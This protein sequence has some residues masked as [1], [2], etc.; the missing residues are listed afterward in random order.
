MAARGKT[1]PKP[2]PTDPTVGFQFQRE[3]EKGNRGFRVH[4]GKYQN[5][6]WQERLSRCKN[7][8]RHI[9]GQITEQ[10][11]S[12]FDVDHSLENL[13][14]AFIFARVS[15]HEHSPGSTAAHKSSVYAL[16][17]TPSI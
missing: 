1:P 15:L 11:F 9:N 8:A 4:V 12:S 10:I 14:K 5:I 3:R 17:V 6:F 13:K 2:S 7:D 16:T